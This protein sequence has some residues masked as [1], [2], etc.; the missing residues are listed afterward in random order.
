MLCA[1]TVPG[2]DN[3][4]PSGTI[5][6]LVEVSSLPEDGSLMSHLLFYSFI[7]FPGEFISL[8]RESMTV[9]TKSV[10]TAQKVRAVNI[11]TQQS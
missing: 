5:I 7:I 4:F 2:S 8:V 9:F 10:T 1:S 3:H 11:N 6:S